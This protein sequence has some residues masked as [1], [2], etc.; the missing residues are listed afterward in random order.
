MHVRPTDTQ[1]TQAMIKQMTKLTGWTASLLALAATASADVK[2]NDNLSLSG[3]AAAAGTITDTSPSTSPKD[4]LFNSGHGNLDSA[5][6]VATGKYQDFTGKVSLLYIPNKGTAADSSGILDAYLAYTQGEITVT[7]GKFLSYMGYESFYT[8]SMNQLTYGSTIV[9]VAGYHTG[10]KVDYAT[11]TFG[12][13]VAVFDSE[14]GVNS[15][16]NRG[17]GNYKH[18][19]SEAY[20]T[21]TGIDKLTLWEGIGYG[22]QDPDPKFVSGY[23]NDFVNDLWAS[24]ALNAK[25]TVAAEWTYADIGTV[26]NNGWLT[27]AQYTFTDKFSG[28]ARISGIK[29]DGASAGTYFT[30]A[31]SYKLT[32]NLAV[33]G[34]VSYA[35]SAAGGASLSGK[36]G[37]FYGVQALFTF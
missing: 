22:D 30:L 3:Y 24:Y 27:F 31:P 21:Y 23:K 32:S 33:R 7:A 35:D 5:E 37:A 1:T 15:G 10:A 14:F 34:E 9:D 12:A 6:V 19:G 13:G 29:Y 25:T 28:I 4:T 20:V 2:I 36:K 16:F 11:K 8:P 17:D 26:K 18:V